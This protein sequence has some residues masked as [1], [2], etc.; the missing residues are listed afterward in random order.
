VRNTCASRP[1]KV[2]D[3]ARIAALRAQGAGW[4]KIAAELGVGVGT[5]Y[6]ANQRAASLP[7]GSKIREK[8]F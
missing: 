3:V 2:L 5:I 4:K 6:E 8:V 7:G 1:R